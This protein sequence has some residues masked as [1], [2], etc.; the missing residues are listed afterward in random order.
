MTG[1]RVGVDDVAGGNHIATTEEHD[2]VTVGVR[3]R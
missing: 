3:G 1:H 2:R